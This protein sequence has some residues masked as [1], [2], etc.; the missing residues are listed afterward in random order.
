MNKPRLPSCAAERDSHPHA[1]P[2]NSRGNP[3]NRA[4]KDLLIIPKEASSLELQNSIQ[5]LIDGICRKREWGWHPRTLTQKGITQK[6][7][8]RP[9]RYQLQDPYCSSVSLSPHTI[10]W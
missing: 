4:R 3:K 2:Q 1:F 7:Y 5:H 8:A 9:L 10:H 6:S